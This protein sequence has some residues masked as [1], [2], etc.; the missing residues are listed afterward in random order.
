MGFLLILTGQDLRETESEREKLFQIERREK[1]WDEEEE[2][3]H[4]KGN[5]WILKQSPSVSES[6]VS[7]TEIL[8]VL[9][10]LRGLKVRDLSSFPSFSLSLSFFLHHSHKMR[11][12]VCEKEEVERI[13]EF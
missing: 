12:N 11:D 10:F 3:G 6:S 8:L 5:E 4:W 1:V 13:S 2:N 7:C 9:Q